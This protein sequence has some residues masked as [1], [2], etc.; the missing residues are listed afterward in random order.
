ML[1]EPGCIGQDWTGLVSTSMGVQKASISG[2]P[3]AKPDRV[4]QSL[5]R[6]ILSG[7][8]GYG[9]QLE[10][11]HA[12][13][14]RFAVSRS[15]V[16]KGL[17]TLA[18]KGLITTQVGIGSFVTFEGQPID[19]ELG[20]TRA[21]SSREEAV[22]TR[23]LRLARITDRDLA[24]TLKLSRPDFIGIDRTR[25]LGASGRIV[26]IERSRV[27]FRPVLSNVVKDGLLNG[28]LSSTLAAAGLRAGSGEEWAEIECL[29][30][31]DAALSGAPP[32]TPFLRTRRLVRD[33][34][35]SIIEYVVSLLDPRHFALHLAF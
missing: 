2:F 34:E 3:I 20:W 19:S 15:T 22:H 7:K 29:G 17:E 31:A 13:V 28:S 8:L 16:R 26:S 11:E 24:V 32:G 30:A 9:A 4:A 21:L 12:L 10:S 25:A 5:E 1:A 27:P 18:G 35:G 33:A 14:R 23:L 6:D